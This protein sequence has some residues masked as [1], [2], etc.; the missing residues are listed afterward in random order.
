MSLQ[1]ARSLGVGS[2]GIKGVNQCIFFF[3]DNRLLEL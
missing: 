1:P 2:F 3:K